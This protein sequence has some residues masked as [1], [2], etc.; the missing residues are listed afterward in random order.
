MGIN[1]RSMVLFVVYFYFN[2][3]CVSVLVGGLFV[4]MVVLI[5]IN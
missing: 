2:A 5:R 1:L 4:F 3:H